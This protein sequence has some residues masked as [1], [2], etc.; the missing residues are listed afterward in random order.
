[1]DS[2]LIQAAPTDKLAKLFDCD[3]DSDAITV[4]DGTDLA[5]I[6][7]HQL[8]APLELELTSGLC[9]DKPG[10]TFFQKPISSEFKTFADLF[11]SS[12]PSLDLLKRAKDFA[13]GCRARADLLPPEVS[14]LL[15]YAAIVSARTRLNHSITEMDDFALKKGLE[16]AI[17]QT[18]LDSAMRT[19]FN[20]G[21]AK[22]TQ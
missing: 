10:S 12:T 21:L 18:W 9:G 17:G 13:K 20:A 16:W 11:T 19:L 3:P 7:Q 2:R 22:L 8:A 4:Y 5:R 6:L 1:M 15:Y 14:T